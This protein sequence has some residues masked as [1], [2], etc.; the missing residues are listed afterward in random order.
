[1]QAIRIRYLDPD[2]ELQDYS[3]HVMDMLRGD[4]SI[5]AHALVRNTI[6]LQ[7]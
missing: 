7:F 5:D 1:M 2:S 6:S 3:L 4:S